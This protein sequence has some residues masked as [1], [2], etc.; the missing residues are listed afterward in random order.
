M[1]IFCYQRAEVLNFT[2]IIFMRLH[3]YIIFAH[4][5]KYSVKKIKKKKVDTN[6]FENNI[7]SER[8]SEGDHRLFQIH[9]FG[10]CHLTEIHPNW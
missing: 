5:C 2:K 6:C 4:L 3:V 9:S 1:S 7:A 8:H 10:H